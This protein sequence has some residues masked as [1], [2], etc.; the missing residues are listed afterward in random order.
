[1]ISYFKCDL[2]IWRYSFI[3]IA[4]LLSPL[5]LYSINALHEKPYFPSSGISQKSSKRSSKYHF[6]INFLTEKRPYLPSLKISK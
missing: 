2:F 5:L 1:M 4:L 6:S 3:D